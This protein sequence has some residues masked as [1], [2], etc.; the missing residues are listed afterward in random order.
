MN[1]YVF[2]IRA[3]LKNLVSAPHLSVDTFYK[4]KA[5]VLEPTVMKVA[6][7]INPELGRDD[8]QTMWAMDMR[9]RFNPEI[10]GPY[11]VNMDNADFSREDL[12]QYLEA[13]QTNDKTSLERFLKDA[14][15]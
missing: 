10:S 9:A 12:E 14:K 1:R 8:Q 2:Y 4:I 5:P 11:M 15:L 13:L 6:M 7:R 3:D